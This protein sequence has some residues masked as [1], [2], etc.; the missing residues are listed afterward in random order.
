MHLDDDVSAGVVPSTSAGPIALETLGIPFK[1]SES[2]QV[3]LEWSP[4]GTAL[5]M[6]AAPSN[7]GTGP[8]RLYLIGIDSG[9]L[10]SSGWREVN[11]ISAESVTDARFDWAPN[12]NRLT[13][14]LGNQ[15][16]DVAQDG[17]ASL[18]HQLAAPNPTWSVL[19]WAPD[20][21]SLLAGIDYDHGTTLYW[22]PATDTADGEIEPVVL[23]ST[24]FSSV[25]WSAIPLEP[26][27]TVAIWGKVSLSP[28]GAC[29]DPNR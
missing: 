17:S 14:G 10:T 22:F 5:A 13:V 23:L 2:S 7:A 27:R 1:G 21:S 20:G 8:A 24:P 15:I 28:T 11:E 19:D 12:T 25:T 6:V 18:G 4:D 26:N 29:Q 9:G 3:D 16:W